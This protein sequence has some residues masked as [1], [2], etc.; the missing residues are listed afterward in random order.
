MQSHR[1]FGVTLDEIGEGSHRLSDHLDPVKTLADFLPQDAQLQLIAISSGNDFYSL[2][3][4]EDLGAVLE[5]AEVQYRAS[6]DEI[7]Q[8][9]E[10]DIYLFKMVRAKY[11]LYPDFE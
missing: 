9:W 5:P 10:R 11:L 6:E 2:L 1:Q 7:R 8:S 3:A 4:R